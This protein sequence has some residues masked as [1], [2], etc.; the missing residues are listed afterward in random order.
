MCFVSLLSNSIWY[1]WPNWLKPLHVMQPL[2]TTFVLCRTNIRGRRLGWEL[3]KLDFITWTSR[4]MLSVMFSL[5]SPLPSI[6][7]FG[8]NILVIHPIKT[9]KLLLYIQTLSKLVWSM[10][11]LFAYLLNKLDKL[12]LPI[13]ST[14]DLVLSWFMLTFEVV[15]MSQVY[16]GQN[17]SLLS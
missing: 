2:P 11:V 8:T 10:I 13:L 1:L 3:S 7:V 5:L 16:K 4:S 15:I 12:F 9:Y 17:T 6:L 14:H